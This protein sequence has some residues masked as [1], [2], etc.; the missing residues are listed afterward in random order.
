MPTAVYWILV[1]M[2]FLA[3]GPFYA[4]PFALVLWGVKW[5]LDRPKL[6]YDPSQD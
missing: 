4:A 6:P 5:L 2:A 3:L 1:L